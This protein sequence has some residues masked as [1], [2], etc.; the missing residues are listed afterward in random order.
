MAE[1]F[2]FSS[3]HLLQGGLNCVYTEIY[4]LWSADKQMFGED[5]NAACGWEIRFYKSILGSQLFAAGVEVV[6]Q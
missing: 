3:V 2:C 5:T 1:F 6:V 4:D